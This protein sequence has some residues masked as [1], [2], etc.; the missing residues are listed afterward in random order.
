[1]TALRGT[2][3]DRGLHALINVVECSFNPGFNGLRLAA[4]RAILA[5]QSEKATGFVRSMLRDPE[6]AAHHTYIPDLCDALTK[7]PVTTPAAEFLF[8]TLLLDRGT[9]TRWGSTAVQQVGAALRAIRPLSAEECQ[10][11]Q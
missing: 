6:F 2:R 9:T 10:R 7:E 4:L 3:S 1:M 5:S 8:S 11:L